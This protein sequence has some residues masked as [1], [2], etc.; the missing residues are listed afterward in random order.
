MG[1]AFIAHDVP[2]CH[3][4]IDAAEWQQHGGAEL[5]SA[6]EWSNR[7]CG[8][9]SLRMILLAQDQ[10]APCL[11]QL[12]KAGVAIGA[13][14]DRGL[15]HA[16]LPSWRPASGCVA[17]RKLSPLRTCPAGWMALRSLHL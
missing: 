14:S 11:T 15:L 12:V 9:A 5:G 8:M 7:V 6:E 13:F 4:Q 10:Q 2:M 3:Q 17:R 16:S 1:A